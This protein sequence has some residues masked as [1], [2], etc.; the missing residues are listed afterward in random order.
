MSGH[1]FTSETLAW[2]S[3]SSVAQGFSILLLLLSLVSFSLPYADSIRPFFIL[4]PIF[5][6]SIY[7][8]SL[9][10]PLISFSFGILFDLISG[11][12]IGIHAVFFLTTHI[13]IKKQRLFL[14]GQPYLMFWAGFAIISS[15]IHILQWLFFSIIHLDLIGFQNIFASN[16]ITILFFPVIAMILAYIQKILP[17]V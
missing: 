9:V 10:S 11:F 5:Y 1:L 15:A 16:A 7:R 4:M 13:I 2:L 17:S 6:W 3:R 14:M 12:P 8:P